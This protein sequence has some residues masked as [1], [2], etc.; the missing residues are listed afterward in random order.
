MSPNQAI[1]L[2]M[3]TLND[4]QGLTY[5]GCVF[6]FVGQS[7]WD[8]LI[9]DGL[10]VNRDVVEVTYSLRNLVAVIRDFVI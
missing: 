9:L 4:A 3:I 8:L 2:F 1:H 5:R 7:H 6:V 10:K